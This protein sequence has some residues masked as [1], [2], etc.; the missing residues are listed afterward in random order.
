MVVVTNAVDVARAEPPEEAAYQLTTD[1]AGTEVITR[2][3]TVALPQYTC[4]DVADGAAGRALT[5]TT[6]VPVK[7]AVQLV[8]A[9]VA[10]TEKVVEAAVKF[11]VG[12]LIGV[13]TPVPAT[14][15]PTLEV[16]LYNW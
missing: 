3:A 5:V 14:G 6:A 9:L 16:P 10:M 12:R 1:P 2:L 8:V 11:P 15:S 7:V 13:A 4:G